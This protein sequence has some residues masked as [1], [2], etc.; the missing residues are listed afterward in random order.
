MTRKYIALRPVNASPTTV[1]GN[2]NQ[3]RILLVLGLS[4]RMKVSCNVR[5]LCRADLTLD[6]ADEVAQTI[7]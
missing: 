2:A 1:G 5:R 3:R 4:L 6:G 7:R